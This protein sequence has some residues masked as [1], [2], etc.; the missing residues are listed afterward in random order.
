M[1]VLRYLFRV[2]YTWPD[3]A[4]PID[5]VSTVY[6]PVSVRA[7]TEAAAL[8]EVETATARYMAAVTAP[9]VITLIGSAAD[10]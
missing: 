7:E 2:M 4:A 6:E 10:V 9:R 8:A 3:G 1:A 5:G